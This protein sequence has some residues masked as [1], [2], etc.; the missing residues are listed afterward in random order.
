MDCKN[1]LKCTFVVDPGQKK[2][3]TSKIMYFFYQTTERR[4]SQLPDSQKQVSQKGQS[5]PIQVQNTKTNPQPSQH[6]PNGVECDRLRSAGVVGLFAAPVEGFPTPV[7]PRSC[8]VFWLYPSS[9]L[10]V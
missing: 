7:R 5:L 4:S 6:K 2:Q 3:K 9:Q 1:E 8:R 10:V